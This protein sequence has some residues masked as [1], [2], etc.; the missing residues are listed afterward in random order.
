MAQVDLILS[1]LKRRSQMKL[2]Y[3]CPKS[4]SIQVNTAMSSQICLWQVFNDNP[5]TKLKF[6]VYGG[7]LFN[8]WILPSHLS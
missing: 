7:L 1:W 6:W 2:H 5:C 8:T 3:K 4:Y